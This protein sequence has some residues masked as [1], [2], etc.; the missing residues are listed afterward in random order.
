MNL[1]ESLLLAAV[2]GGALFMCGLPLEHTHEPN[3]KWKPTMTCLG[4]AASLLG[5]FVIG[6][7]VIALIALYLGVWPKT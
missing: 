3:G 1:A 5:F 7:A 4:A 2:I 6:V